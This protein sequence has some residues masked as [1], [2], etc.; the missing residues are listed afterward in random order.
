MAYLAGYFDG[1]GSI[2]IAGGSLCVR[3]T[4]TYKPALER[5]QQLFGGS[6]DIHNAGDEKS[7]L[8]WVWRTYGKRAEDALAAIEPYLV[9]K[10][11]QAYLGKHFRSLPKGPDRDRVVQ[12]LTLLK[13]TTHQR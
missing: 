3:I 9:E 6:V 13:R 7:R 10:G 4:N 1:E 2:G 11:P 5:F 12:A 8:S